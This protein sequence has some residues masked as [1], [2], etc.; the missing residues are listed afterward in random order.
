MAG[1]NLENRHGRAHLVQHVVASK[2]GLL[3]KNSSSK[4]NLSCSLT[5]M[6]RIGSIELFQKANQIV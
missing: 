2:L 6:I 4:L 5:E 1:F 3:K